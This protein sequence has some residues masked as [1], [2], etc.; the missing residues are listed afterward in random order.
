[1]VIVLLGALFVLIGLGVPIAFSIGL[2][3]LLYL[4]LCG[5]PSFLVAQRTVQGIYSYPF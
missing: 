4:T 2:S 3:S 5:Y 1:M